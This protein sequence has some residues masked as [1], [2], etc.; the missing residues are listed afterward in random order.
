M[1]KAFDAEGRGLDAD[2]LRE[3]NITTFQQELLPGT[4]GK[5]VQSAVSNEKSQLLR[6]VLPFVKT[7]TNVL[8]YGWKMTP[9]LGM[10]GQY[11]GGLS[12]SSVIREAGLTVS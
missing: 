9:R 7:P 4:L 10:E 6:L 11:D 5:A 3:A 2:A 12:H 8:R 1:D